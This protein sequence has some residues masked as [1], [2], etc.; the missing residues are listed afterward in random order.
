MRRRLWYVL[1][2]GAC[3]L[4]GVWLYGRFGP[5]PRIDRSRP[6]HVEF[7]RGS[8]MAGLETVAID[9]TGRLVAYRMKRTGHRED[10]WETATAPLSDEEIGR[11]LDAVESDGLLRLRREYADR[12]IYDGTQCVFWVRQDGWE[13]AVYCDNDFPPELVR[14]GRRLDDLLVGLDLP[15]ADVPPAESR[16]HERGLWESIRRR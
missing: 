15:W 14:F 9:H 7:G 4:A 10:R 1:T 11:V 12:P 8:G 13:R 6:W 2:A 5:A 16:R 3:V